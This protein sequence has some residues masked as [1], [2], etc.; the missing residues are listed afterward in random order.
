VG[1][2]SIVHVGMV[3]RE[4]QARTPLLE[5]SDIQTQEGM[6]GGFPVLLEKD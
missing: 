1:D 3:Q 4:N 2:A 6:K 5:G